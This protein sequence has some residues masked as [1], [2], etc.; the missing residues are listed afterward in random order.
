[1]KHVVFILCLLVLS[2]C[3][4]IKQDFVFDESTPQTV[5]SDI[6]HVFSKLNR[7]DK[8]DFSMALLAIRFSDV[9]SVKDMLVIPP[10]I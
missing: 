3:A 1:M 7:S 9:P 2:A 10:C 4:S 8:L 5:E 6:N